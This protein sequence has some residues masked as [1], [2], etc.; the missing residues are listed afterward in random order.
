[1]SNIVPYSIHFTFEDLETISNLA[2]V[3]YSPSEI[4]LYLQVN[5]RAFKLELDNPDSLVREAYD[6]GQL[7][8]KF[9]IDNAMLEAAKKGNLTATQIYDKHSEANKLE[10]LKNKYI[11]GDEA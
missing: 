9:E 1:M 11:Y 5:K 4:A 3:N 10:Q 2:A 6:R 8:A 7:L